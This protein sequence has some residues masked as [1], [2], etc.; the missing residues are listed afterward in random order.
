[1]LAE[2]DRAERFL[3]KMPPFP[4]QHL[5]QLSHA[6]SAQS[7]PWLLPPP[8]REDRRSSAIRTAQSKTAELEIEESCRRREPLQ[9]SRCSSS[10]PPAEAL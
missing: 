5:L 10:A 9:G 1:M 7:L 2:G 6:Q 8:G 3:S 4:S